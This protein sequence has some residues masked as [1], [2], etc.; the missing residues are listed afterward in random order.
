[1][2]VQDDAHGEAADPGDVWD[3]LSF[4]A[5][6]SRVHD[7]RMV[8]LFDVAAETGVLEALPGSPEDVAVTLGLD[9]QGVRIVLEALVVWGVVA[10]QA[11]RFELTPRFAD[12]DEASVL[13]HH[14]R[15][16]R[17]WSQRLEDRVRGLDRGEHDDRQQLELWLRALAVNARASA[18][19]A[20]DAC[21]ARLPAARRVLDLGGG[22]GEYALEFARR[23]L[24][25]TVQ[26][27]ADVIDVARRDERLARAGVR[28]FAGD[29]F[30]VLADG[31]FDLVFCAGVA[32]TYDEEHN[33]ELFG[34]LR[35]LIADGGMLAVHTFLRGRHPLAAIF[36]VQMLRVARGGDTHSQDDYRRW[37]RRAGYGHV[38]VV[39]LGRP[40]ES[41]LLAT[42]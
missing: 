10:S 25:A 29:F 37:L 31:P 26:D 30:E 12:A 6:P 3:R 27:R 28:L 40:P 18:P 42:P 22:H 14:A 19:G 21:L 34:R 38:N 8:L 24:E 16:I 4:L 36:A 13:R 39:H 5:P 2:G 32:Y 11:G 1:M 9:E 41:L 15:S 7:W 23:G 17:L 33:L 35:P 20:A